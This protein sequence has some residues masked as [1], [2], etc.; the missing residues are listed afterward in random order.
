M[1]DA[2][3]AAVARFVA[4]GNAVDRLRAEIAAAIREERSFLTELIGQLNRH[5]CCARS[6][7]RSSAVRWNNF[8]RRG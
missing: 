2:E 7:S 1:S 6:T 4:D 3:A 5:S 8:D